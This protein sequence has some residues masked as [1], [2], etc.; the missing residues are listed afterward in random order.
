MKAVIISL[1][2]V[3]SFIDS[4]SQDNVNKSD[5]RGLQFAE[6]FSN[7]PYFKTGTQTYQFSSTDPA[8]DQ[9]NDFGHWLY[10]DQDSNSVLADISGPGC[11]Y[12]IWSTGNNGDSDLLKVY[13]DGNKIA[14]INETFNQF[15]NYP[16][17]RQKPQVGSGGDKYL[18]W[19]SYMPIPF[20][21]SCKIVRKGN[22]RPFYNIT[23]HTYTK[24]ENVFSWT[25]KENYEKIEQMWNHPDSDPKKSDGNKTY[26]SMVKLLPH[27]K[28]TIMEQKGTG[29]IASIKISNYLQE[30][31]LRIK[32]YW[33]GEATP[34]VDAPVKW[35]FGSIDNGGDV[36]A[37]GV[38]TINRSGYCYFPMPFWKSAK[39]EIDNQSDVSTDSMK[40]E[41][42]YNPKMYIESQCGYF[43]ATVHE[44][45]KPKNKYTCLK[46]TGRGHVIGMAKRM[47]KG[48]H[49]CE[50][51]EI[52]YIDNR[53]YP[54]IYGTGEEDYNN[55]AW[56]TNIYNSY[57][58]HGCI[59]N[60]CYYRLNYPDMI[61]Y[62]QALDMEFETWEPFYIASIVWYYEKN[63]SS[64]KLTDSLDIYNP[65]SEKK[66]SYTI[67]NET[68]SGIKKGVYPG[69]QIYLDS[70]SD[71]GR[72]FKG[73]SQFKVKIDAE[74]KGVRI[75]LRT[76]N[77]E[78]Q[79]AKIWIDEKPVTERLW[80]VCKNKFVALWVDAD[81]EIPAEY[82]SGKNN[83]Q[84]KI[85][86]TP[87]SQRPWSE[88]NYKVFSY[89][90]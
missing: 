60:D 38:G 15:H 74:N 84:I 73:Y 80:E 1:L 53:R 71:D 90:Y 78:M 28:Q 13:I 34:S 20:E 81:F 68:W 19:W 56:W 5:S 33:D 55:N 59:G 62:E 67:T 10:N 77:G 3:C 46:T 22:F 39:I 11:I 51:D 35:F 58:T 27:Q 29:S 8:E 48:G 54:D 6:Q 40:I 25:G 66:H 16:P 52:F 79:I 47:P 83:I 50:G 86:Y 87:E 49:A 42:Q 17:L 12:L 18:A 45:E 31:E 21:K 30:K 32:I 61:I 36:K 26:L 57:P 69:K 9:F 43:N 63:K 37:L 72:A 82:T 85:E 88:F 2:I 44:S 24:P 7:L 14:G 65:T 89:L 23:Y 64:L 41:I 76:S 70:I 4:Y 75:R